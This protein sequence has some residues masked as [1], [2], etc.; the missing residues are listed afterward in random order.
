MLLQY[1]WFAQY[2]ELEPLNRGRSAQMNF[3]FLLAA[4]FRTR[5]H[6]LGKL[7]LARETSVRSCLCERPLLLACVRVLNCMCVLSCVC[8]YVCLLA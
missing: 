8:L 4:T 6:I 2:L 7:R 5:I 1:D 3:S